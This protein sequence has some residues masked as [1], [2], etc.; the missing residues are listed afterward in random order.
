MYHI[1][2]R[3]SPS[4]TP[5]GVFDSRDSTR[6]V[7]QIHDDDMIQSSIMQVSVHWESNAVTHQYGC[8]IL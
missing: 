5:D 7:L 8:S 4:A 3:C 1:D 6:T 2:D